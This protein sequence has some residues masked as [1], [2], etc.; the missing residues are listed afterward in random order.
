[1][2]EPKV[3]QLTAGS[4]VLGLVLAAGAVTLA[5]P[6]D[7]GQRTAERAVAAAQARTGGAHHQAAG[8]GRPGVPAPAPS[9]PGVLTTLGDT[10][11]K[12]AAPPPGALAAVLDPLLAAPGLGPLRTA[13]VIDV[14]TGKQLY[15]NGAAA[16]MTPASTIK[17]ATSVAAL[18]ALGPDHRIPTTVVATPDARRLTLVGGGDPTLDTA[19]LRAL[20]ADTARALRGRGV[21]SVRLAYDTSR[22]AGPGRHPIGVNDNI[23][24]VTALMTNEG[25]LDGSTSGP[26]PRS[27][28][29]AGDTARAFADLLTR[30]G[31]A[32]EAAPAPARAPEKA[33]MLARTWSQPLSA[34]VEHTL[35]HSDNDLAE[36]LARQTALASGRPASFQGAGRA[37]ADRLR[38]LG[39]PVKGARF[40][41][42]SGL[43]R[44]DR[45]S[46]TMLTGLLARAADP[47][48]PELRP[49]LTGLPV[50]GFTGT[51]KDRY[52]DGSPGAGLIRAKTGT[53]SGVNALAGTVVTA[54]GR[55]L[56][57]AFLA[58][59]TSSPHT[60]QPALEQ[61]ETPRA[62]RVLGRPRLVA[63]LPEN[64]RLLVAERR[65]HRHAPQRP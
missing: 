49:V 2:L 56:A 4:A 34:L 12:A 7:S 8:P 63:G 14:A 47:A 26:A 57:F 18:T 44:H 31:V 16:P 58:D 25:R 53:L 45:L 30:Q 6:W 20:A 19:R 9:A 43:D 33:T 42:G 39:L 36:A 29:P 13:S 27:A 55:L 37:V 5:G 32:T 62:V 35:T 1:M 3:V 24:P 38:E 28:D 41:D 59:R 65:R 23:A 61:Q 50:G 64:R 60:A 15:G 17:I 52:A 40:A 21:T 10:A 11:A 48:R 54:D 22:Y 46:A 51:L